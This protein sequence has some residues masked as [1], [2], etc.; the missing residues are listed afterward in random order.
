[1]RRPINHL[2]TFA[3]L[4]LLALLAVPQAEAQQPGDPP[5]RE[6]LVT[7][8]KAYIAVMDVRAEMEAEIAGATSQEQAQ[9]IQEQASQEMAAAVEDHGLTQERYGAITNML[10]ANQDLLQEFQEIY[11]ELT[12]GSGGL[13]FS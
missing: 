5:D 12:E 9:Q 10:N 8:T 1:M 2:V 7:F 13:V 3:T 4:S 6:E 11:S